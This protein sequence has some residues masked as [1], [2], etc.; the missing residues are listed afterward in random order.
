M[1]R[2]TKIVAT[3]GPA[4]DDIAS[5]TALISA[6]VD[7]VRLN[8]SHGSIEGHL[9]RLDRADLVALAHRGQGLQVVE[10]R[11]AEVDP[12]GTRA[13]RADEVA[14]ELALGRLDRFA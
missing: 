5:L 12:V 7:V 10:R 2:R 13:A 3:I 8:L 14:A 11:V 4:T 9:E 6:G 1:T